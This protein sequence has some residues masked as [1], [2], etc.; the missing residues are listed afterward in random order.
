MS[1]TRAIS[2]TSRREL[3]SS[4][5]FLQGKA[6]EEIHAIRTETL[7][8]FLPGRA[9]D[10]SAPLYCPSCGIPY[11]CI[12]ESEREGTRAETRIGL[13]TKRTSPFKSAWGSVQSTIGSRGVR[14]KDARLLATHSIRIFSLHFPSRESPCAVSFRFSSAT[15]RYKDRLQNHWMS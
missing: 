7:A 6:P 11:R 13:S 9:K 10:L 5:S 2:T 3:S 4:S 12:A 1:G 14:M 8:C 15:N